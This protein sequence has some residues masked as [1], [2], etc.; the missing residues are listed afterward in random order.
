M[1]QRIVVLREGSSRE[2]AYAGALAAMLSLECVVVTMGASRASQVARKNGSTLSHDSVAKNVRSI[3][4]GLGHHPKHVRVL[5]YD[6]TSEGFHAILHPQDLVISNVQAGSLHTHA[7]LAPQNETG[8]FRDGKEGI[9]LPL[10]DNELATLTY[11]LGLHLSKY[12]LPP[13][14]WVTLYHTTWKKSGEVDSAPIS[15]ISHKANAILLSAEQEGQ[16]LGLTTR[17]M[18]RTDETVVHGIAEA[19]LRSDASLVVVTRD[20]WVVLGDYADQ[21]ALLLSGAVPLLVLPCNPT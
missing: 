8:V 6:G 21:L 5:E 9:L 19:A 20:P 1:F 18:V 2:I 16:S 12:L 14:G 7:V 15:H 3:M 10:G 17:H 13:H 4:S 11:R